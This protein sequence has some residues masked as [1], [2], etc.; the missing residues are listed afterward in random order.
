VV[1]PLEGAISSIG[2]VR[3]M[4]SNISS[5]QSSIQV[6]FKSNVNIKT[7]SLRLE[8]KIKEVSASLPEGFTVRVMRSSF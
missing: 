2:G 3:R 8:E 1:I 4:L 6:E 5:R 7:T